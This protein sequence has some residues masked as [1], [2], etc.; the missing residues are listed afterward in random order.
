MSQCYALPDL[1]D[2][3]MNNPHLPLCWGQMRPDLG[4]DAWSSWY[5]YHPQLCPPVCV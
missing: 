3:F 2:M 1:A 5:A 4:G